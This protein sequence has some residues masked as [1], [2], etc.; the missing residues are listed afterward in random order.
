M[1]KISF[2]DRQALRRPI[3]QT[4]VLLASLCLTA[5][6]APAQTD[7]EYD[8]FT[9][10]PIQD[11]RSLI[12]RYH[13]SD[14]DVSY[15][16]FDPASGTP[17]VEHRA[18]QAR[19]PASTS[20]I[21]TVNAA[22]Q[23]LGPDY[24]FQTSLLATGAAHPPELN[25]DLYLRGGGDPSLTSDDL[26]AFA[27]ALRTAGIS[28][29]SGRFVYDE[30]L[31]PRLRE[32]DPSQPDAVVYNPGISALSLNYNRVQVRWQHA[33]GNGDFVTTVLSPADGGP[34]P[35]D[36]IG[37]AASPS[38]GGSAFQYAGTGND[39]W[40]LSPRLA[41]QGATTLPV[42]NDAGRVAANVFQ[43]LCR[44]YGIELPNPESGQAPASARVI[45][46]HASEP[47][48]TIASKVL[49]HS[50]NMAAEMIGLVSSRKLTSRALPLALS[51]QA[52]ARWYQYRLKNADWTGFVAQNHSGLSRD[53]RHSSRQLA[54]ILRDG[55][56]MGQ[57]G[58]GLINVM[59]PAAWERGSGAY[60]STRVKSGTMSYADGLVGYLTGHTGRQ[61]GFVI[62]ITDFGQ[63]ASFD[64]VMDA[65]GDAEAPGSRRWTGRAKTFEQALVKTWIAQH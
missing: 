26:R 44:E 40:L 58:N 43:N 4:L 49:R 11:P 12:D 56:A 57:R 19:I 32:I 18:D 45:H 9:E 35:V 34:V 61:Y 2:L 48:P 62:L 29:I 46:T 54:A 5:V 23:L 28:R 33:R 47:L 3:P 20:K 17:I 64:G 27:S 65:Y 53:S 50:N 41:A 14:G 36:V 51:A 39:R 31:L 52:L 10:T 63:R 37:F 16:L 59:S 1:R 42:K 6:P 38:D 24:R 25:G 55:W 60:A 13:L 21:V 30:S 8:S 15:L 7:T 22:L